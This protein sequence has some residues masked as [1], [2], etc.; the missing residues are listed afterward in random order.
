MCCPTRPILR[1]SSGASPLEQYWLE[2]LRSAVQPFTNHVA[3]TWFNDLSFD[4]ILKRSAALPPKSAIYLFS[5]VVDAAGSSHEGG[6]VL[7]RLRAV[8]SAPI[9]SYAD[10]NFGKGI[11]GGPL[12][13][14]NGAAQQAAG[15]AA[16]MLG[17][18]P[19]GSI[20]TPPIG[21]GS[22]KYDW[23]ELQ[24]WSI[25]EA[26]LPPGSEVHFREPRLWERYRW[27]MTAI[28][29]AILLQAVMITWLLFER[30]RRSLAEVE[31][32]DRRRE[33]IHLNRVATATVLS[34]S[35]AHELSQPLGAILINAETARQMLR[36]ASP[37]LARGG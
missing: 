20:T 33:A 1:S 5:L 29:A 16:R 22:P 7:E 13:S 6:K 15:V 21:F 35:I 2:Q 36:S 11:V 37:D 14:V 12:I 4:E 24:R 8:S 26:R 28:L 27:Q 10:T 34:S 30:R 32:N 9:F 19:P 18:E 31:A 23:R 17:G 3:F 25:S